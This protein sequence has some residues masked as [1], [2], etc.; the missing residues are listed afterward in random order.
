MK[1]AWDRGEEYFDPAR[2]DILERTE[3]RLEL[4][5]EHL[6]DPIA[7]LAKALE[8]LENAWGWHL[9]RS[10]SWQVVWLQWPAILWVPRFCKRCGKTVLGSKASTHRNVPGKYGPHGELFFCFPHAEGVSGGFKRGVAKSFRAQGVRV[11][12]FAPFGSGR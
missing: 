12:W 11:D 8:C 10:F 4:W 7:A 9:V 5:E 3:T 6:K 2:E 1:A